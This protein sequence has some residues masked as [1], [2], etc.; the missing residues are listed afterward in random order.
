MKQTDIKVI[1]TTAA[2]SFGINFFPL[3]HP[4]MTQMPESLVEYQ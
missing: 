1:V 2:A 4:I 3:C